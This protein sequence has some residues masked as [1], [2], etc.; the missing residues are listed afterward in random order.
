MWL[1]ARTRRP[2][3]ARS[4]A[5]AS[6]WLVVLAAQ[7]VTSTSTSP[8]PA[9]GSTPATRIRPPLTWWS[10]TCCTS[11]G[12]ITR[13]PPATSASSSVI[14][15]PWR[16]SGLARSPRRSS[17]SA[18]MPLDSPGHPF[19]VPRTPPGPRLAAHGAASRRR[20][21]SARW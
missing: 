3:S 2:H 19:G 13:P 6:R 17:G 15:I 7:A 20:L 4:L 1:K 21:A 10:M 5:R 8:S 11:T 9:S 12:V 14:A 16:S 18:R